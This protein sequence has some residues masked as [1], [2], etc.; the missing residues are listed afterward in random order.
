M[1][2]NEMKRKP[3]FTLIEL[4]VVI[5]II[6][7]L[8][9]LLLPAL[10][11]GKD[12]A[13]GMVCLNNL[14]QWGLATQLYVVD[15]NDFLPPDGS[16]NGI[17]VNS[18]WYIDLPR[19]LG[20]RPYNQ[21]PW[22]TNASIAP[23]KSIWICPANTNRSNGNNLFHYCLNEHVNGTGANNAP[24]RHSTIDNPAQVVWLFDNGKRAAVAQQN[25]V[26]TN[27]H[28][29]GAQF[30]FLDG[31]SGRFRNTEYWDFTANK[32]RTNNQDIIW[33]PNVN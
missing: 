11:K 5:A 14:K 13:K 26:H 23:E 33:I 22:R 29:K 3:A 15:N 31:H 25:N 30:T 4:L 21:L 8:A 12:K 24:V 7:I 10:G 2:D 27:L 19:V 20:I 6:A 28:N 16:P 18:G 32:G 1:V 17:S 9:S